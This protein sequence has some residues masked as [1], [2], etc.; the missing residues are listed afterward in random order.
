M[1]ILSEKIIANFLKVLNY[2]YEGTKYLTD[3]QVVSICIHGHVV[4]I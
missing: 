4:V 3:I 1:V 2:N